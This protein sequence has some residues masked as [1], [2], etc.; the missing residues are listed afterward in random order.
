MPLYV[1]YPISFDTACVLFNEGRGDLVELLD[2]MEET[3]LEFVYVDKNQYI[4]GLEVKIGN[5]FGDFSNVDDSLITILEEKKKLIEIIKIANIDISNFM[6]QP[7]GE[8]A[9]P[10]P[11]LLSI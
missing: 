5:L 2:R 3:G 8:E 9:T 7:I 4:L 1:G 11:Y 10:Q 6:L